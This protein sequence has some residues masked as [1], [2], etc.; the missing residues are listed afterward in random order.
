MRN[1][2]WRGWS[3]LARKSP[4]HDIEAR[5]RKFAE[6]K[7][8]ASPSLS[9]RLFP[10]SMI[11]QNGRRLMVTFQPLGVSTLGAVENMALIW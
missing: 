10:T 9:K 2:G 11:E 7:I 4:A 5:I 3:L 1:S 8:P 6:R